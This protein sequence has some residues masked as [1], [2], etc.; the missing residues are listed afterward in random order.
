MSL[1]KRKPAQRRQRGSWQDYE[2]AKQEWAHR[3]PRATCEQYDAAM[4][5]IAQRMGL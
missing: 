1:A 2:Y 3:N 5:A 4:R